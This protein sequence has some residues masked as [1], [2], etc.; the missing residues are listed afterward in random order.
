M[1]KL[2]GSES[3]VRMADDLASMA[4]DG[5]RSALDGPDDDHTRLEYAIRHAQATTI[6]GGTSEVQRSIIAQR[7]LGLPRSY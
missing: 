6:Y 3:G 7:H 5:M 2:F 1:A 4:P